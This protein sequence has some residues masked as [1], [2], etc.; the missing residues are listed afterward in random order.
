M[1]EKHRARYGG[2]GVVFMPSRHATFPAH[3][4][5]HQPGGSFRLSIL[6]FISFLLNNWLLVIELN[7]QLPSSFQVWGKEARVRWKSSD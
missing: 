7:F 6:E 1:G 2:G 3:R 4:C 5:V